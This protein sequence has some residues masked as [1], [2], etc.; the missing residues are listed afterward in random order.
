MSVPEPLDTL[1]AIQET[2]LLDKGERGRPRA[3]RML[4]ELDPT[5][6]KLY[7]LFGLDAYAP[8]R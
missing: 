1:A 6:R 4:T 7:D 8:K 2:V 3:Q 5:Q